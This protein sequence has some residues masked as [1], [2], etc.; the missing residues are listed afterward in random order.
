MKHL[1]K[2]ITIALLALVFSAT[3]APITT[4]GAAGLDAIVGGASAFI[5][6]KKVI[7]KMDN[8]GQG[9][10]LESTMKK[11][12]Y[13]DDPA[14]QDRADG[15]LANLSQS[16]LVTRKYEVYVN[17]SKDVN[18]FMTLGAVMSINKG[19][20]DKMDDSE[21]A[22]VM[23]HEL[24][25]GEH[26]DIV[27]GIE[28]SVGLSTAISVAAGDANLLTGVIQNF[29]ENQVFTMKQEKNA[30]ELGFKILADSSY[31]IGGASSAMTVLYNMYGDKSYSEGLSQV[32]LPN[33]HP[34]SK[35]RAKLNSQRMTE[36]SKGHVE[37]RDL[38]VYINNHYLYSLVD[39]GSYSAQQRAYLMGGK[40]ARLFHDGTMSQASAQG[41][42]VFV[43]GISIVTTPGPEV[44]SMVADNINTALT[45]K[46]NVKG[47]KDKDT[48]DKKKR[49]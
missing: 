44:A 3:A 36:F 4:V 16:P 30:D 18:A 38:D 17:P 49:K 7:E 23:A 31:N 33:N 24:S 45:Q 27:K 47:S 42:S 37:V 12:G 20:M 29:V 43:N 11:T 39:G 22:Y 21:L 19:L 41:D 5:Y 32:L 35:E 15:I 40:L 10:M 14:Y 8:E 13:L 9:R 26:R 48:K 28:K 6:V 34:K 2:K 1:K 25:H 46:A